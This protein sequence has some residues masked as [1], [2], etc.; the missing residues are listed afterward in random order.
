MTA[1]GLV[2]AFVGACYLAAGSLKGD[3]RWFSGGLLLV[4]AGLT[5]IVGAR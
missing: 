4:G 2:C 3:G 1:A 5:L